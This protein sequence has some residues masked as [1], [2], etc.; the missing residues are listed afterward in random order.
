MAFYGQDAQFGWDLH[1]TPAVRFARSEPAAGE[2]V[3]LD[4][5]TQLEWQ[6]CA[7]GLTGSTCGG[8]SSSQM[9]WAGAVAYCE[10][11]TWGGHSDWRLPTVRELSTIVDAGRVEPNIDP[12][13]FPGTP[14][15]TSW[16]SSSV[17]GSGSGAWYV[18]FNYGNVDTG[19]KART[20]PC[21]LRAPRTVGPLILRFFG[22]S[23]LSGGTAA[24][25]STNLRSPRGSPGDACAGQ[26]AV[27]VTAP[28]SQE[29]EKVRSPR[30]AEEHSSKCSTQI[31]FA[32]Q[33]IQ[34]GTT[35]TAAES[36]PEHPN[37]SGV[38]TV[39]VPV[40]GVRPVTSQS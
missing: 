19:G 34:K 29:Y 24:R 40:V 4:R 17:A 6:G 5:M 7:A 36:V 15:H 21:P 10:A 26:R 18:N 9:D 3:V 25:S 39:A 12:P 32:S 13:A 28:V 38:V 30:T 16:S 35:S 31:R 8:G 37:D 33:W 1:V 27:Q 14:S 20:I 2:P 23:V 22:P 11:L